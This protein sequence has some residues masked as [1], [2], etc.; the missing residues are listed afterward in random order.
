[1]SRI[2]RR[3]ITLKPRRRFDVE[4]RKFQFVEIPTGKV[5]DA[6]RLY[7]YHDIYGKIDFIS[8]ED[9]DNFYTPDDMDVEIDL[10]LE[11]LVLS[12]S[13]FNNDLRIR[14][15]GLDDDWN[16]PMD[17]TAVEI[18]VPY[19]KVFNESTYFMIQVNFNWGED[20][21]GGAN[22]ARFRVVP[23]TVT[24]SPNQ[25]ELTFKLHQINYGTGQGT[26]QTVN[27]LRKYP[28]YNGTD[29]AY[30]IRFYIDD[31]TDTVKVKILGDYT[32]A[33]E[34]TLSKTPPPGVDYCDYHRWKLASF[35]GDQDNS[36]TARTAISYMQFLKGDGEGSRI[37]YHV[38]RNGG[39][40]W[41]E[42]SGDSMIVSGYDYEDLDL[43]SQGSGERE[44][45]VRASVR[46]P[47]LLKGLG[48]AWEA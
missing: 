12:G 33:T 9:L 22:Y 30:R 26:E 48:M 24:G 23:D 28:D 35:F 38:S 17:N 41:L 29:V 3:G 36:S 42:Q 37:V 11:A 4:N 10:D 5:L 46:W 6:V 15:P 8:A 45:L 34:H 1:M 14:P 31:V 32:G 21:G 18:W 27:D 40:D 2:I 13:T 47:A 39:S 20:K 44:L 19:F 25:N 7:S 16:Q 43:S